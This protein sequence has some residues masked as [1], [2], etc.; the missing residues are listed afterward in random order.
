M[1]T[2]LI[3]EARAQL[4]TAQQIKFD[5]L[6]HIAPSELVQQLTLHSVVSPYERYATGSH[7]GPNTVTCRIKLNPQF[8]AYLRER[9]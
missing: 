3:N 2:N 8:K 5:M 1:T 6:M 7:R 9:L 4:T